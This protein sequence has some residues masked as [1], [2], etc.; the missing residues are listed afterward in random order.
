MAVY[1]LYWI[2][3]NVGAIRI[4]KLDISLLLLLVYILVNRYLIQPDYAFSIR[5]FELIGLSLLYL[6][7][8]GISYKYYVWF[9]VVIVLSGIIQAIYGLLQF[10]GYYYSNHL[11]FDV[12]GS[13]FNP[14]PYA[15][16]LAITGSI[17]FALYLF[18]KHIRRI[19]G[20]EGKTAVLFFKYVLPYISL[21]AVLCVILILPLTESRA[22]YLSFLLS[23]ALLLELR[24]R[25]FKKLFYGKLPK[26]KPARHLQEKNVQ[27]FKASLATFKSRLSG[28]SSFAKKGLMIMALIMGVSSLVLVL[29]NLKIASANGRLLIWKISTSMLKEHIC[30]GVGFDGFASSYMNYQA[31]YFSQYQNTA[32]INIADNVYYAYNEGLQ[33]FIENGFIGFLFLL[34]AGIT[35]FRSTTILRN[36]FLMVFLKINMITLI[37]FACFS[38]PSHILPIKII[39]VVLLGFL[40]GLDQHAKKIMIPVTTRYLNYTLRVICTFAIVLTLFWGIKKVNGL[41]KG[42]LRWNTIKNANIFQDYEM[43]AKEYEVLLPLFEKNGLFLFIY[44]KTLYRAKQ[45]QGAI[46]VLRKA[47][48]YL[49]TYKTQMALADAY[50]K[51]RE[52]K[53]AAFSYQKAS[54]MVP[55]KLYP[56]YLLV[57]LFIET[58]QD[59]KAFE[60]A[61]E[62]ITGT[63]KIQ[64]TTVRKIKNEMQEFIDSYK[65]PK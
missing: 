24:Y 49:S 62:I 63:I 6:V 29:Y 14:A 54:D 35:L 60:L 19:Y 42:F 25:Y 53:K 56:K 40:A 7:L 32:E 38:Y 64:S 11:K 1:V 47:E 30:F 57:K 21:A 10:Q 15:G 16:F 12:T 27:S 46:T 43:S 33:F 58:D 61:K 4:S 55:I 45:Y 50:K 3:T 65:P 36:T 48:K 26:G 18:K 23:C 5:Y 31:V 20:N 41:D 44:G 39:S 8:R 52:Y 59:K 51:M 9:L 37:I 34:I 13:F 2:V 28:K 22:S 17:A